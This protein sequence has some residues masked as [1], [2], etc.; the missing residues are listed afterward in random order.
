MHTERRKRVV[1]E[2]DIGDADGGG[3]AR[4]R[5]R[6][7]LLLA[8][9]EVDTALANLGGVAEGKAGD[10]VRQRARVQHSSCVR[11]PTQRGRPRLGLTW[12][13]FCLRLEKM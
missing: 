10:I 1:E 2:D 8:A 3:V 12:L 9:G 5:E 4:A 7:P 11:A 13:V 6:D